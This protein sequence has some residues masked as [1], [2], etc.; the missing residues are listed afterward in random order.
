MKNKLFSITYLQVLLLSLLLSIF[1]A[2][3]GCGKQPASNPSDPNP[4]S[5]NQ[6]APSSKQTPPP[7]I[8]PVTDPMIER[9]QKA[10][11]NFL[12]KKLTEIKNNTPNLDINEKS[13]EVDNGTVL[14][15]LAKSLDDEEI[16]QVLLDHGAKIDQQD[17]DNETALHIAARCGRQQLTRILLE[18]GANICLKNSS[19]ESPFD[20]AIRRNHPEIATLIVKKLPKDDPYINDP[21]PNQNN[22]TLLHKAIST[23]NSELIEALL[24]KGA[25]VDSRDGEGKTPFDLTIGLGKAALFKIFLE[26]GNVA[27]I[28]QKYPDLQEATL[29]HIAV[30]EDNSDLLKLL[31]EK[32]A[33]VNVK[34]KEDKT[35]IDLAAE[36]GK[37]A[38]LKVFL[39]KGNVADINQKYTGRNDDATLL[40]IAVMEDNSDLLKLL[41]EKEAKV[42]SMNKGNKT[43]IDLAIDQENTALLKLFVEKGKLVDINKKFGPY[44]ESLLHIAV[45]KDDPNLV[46]ALLEKDAD[47]NSMNSSN[48]TPISIA[49]DQ[50]KIKSREVFIKKGKLAID[51]K[52]DNYHGNTLLHIAVMADDLEFVQYLLQAGVNPE[53][54]ND[55]D[56]TPLE[57]VK[58]KPDEPNATAIKQALTDAINKK[59]NP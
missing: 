22:N 1:F 50:G 16:L 33:Q 55:S 45:S 14:H 3:C 40:H 24:E 29:L 37:T 49:I 48:E 17:K 58:L 44:Q 36:K 46:E 23:E 59:L 19:N 31:L 52:L 54:E 39:E 10:G 11:A 34:D 4:T 21:D 8:T 26:K 43:P 28:N 7:P 20:L 2:Q 53:L 25:K 51:K 12:V 56:Q 32:G 6:T 30:M 5:T 42:D 47:V 9:A 35:P 15:V 27:D 57:L 41:L 38:L 13:P 18:K